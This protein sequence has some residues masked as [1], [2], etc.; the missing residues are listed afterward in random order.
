MP[1]HSDSSP[2]LPRTFLNATRIHYLD[3]LRTF[4]VLLVVVHH[5]A[6][7]KV[8]LPS[9]PIERVILNVFTA[10]NKAFLWSTFYLVSGFS[11]SLSLTTYGNGLKFLKHR[12]LPLAIHALV[13][14]TV[15][16]TAVAWVLTITTVGQGMFGS[17]ELVK[18]LLTGP[19]SYLGF[20][21]A[22]DGVLVG[23][24]AL[25]APRLSQ[26]LGRHGHFSSLLLPTSTVVTLLVCTYIN[27]SQSQRTI[28]PLPSFLSALISSFD[29]PLPD[30]PFSCI[31]AYTI[32]AHWVD[33]R[34][35]LPG[36]LTSPL[37]F[38][39]SLTASYAYLSLDTTPS[40]S[41]SYLILPF[42]PDLRTCAF[43]LWDT[44]ASLTL[45]LSLLSFFASTSVLRRSWNV[46]H[47][48]LKLLVHT[49]RFCVRLAT[50][51]EYQFR[52]SSIWLL[53]WR[54]VIDRSD[55]SGRDSSSDS[56]GDNQGPARVGKQ[57]GSSLDEF[58]HVLTSAQIHL[59]EIVVDRVGRGIL[60]YISSY[61]RIKKLALNYVVS[62][63]SGASADFATGFYGLPIGRRMVLWGA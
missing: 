13:W 53:T 16:R 58:W 18:E 29:Y 25:G 22:L 41:I 31:I 4:L 8:A 9:H 11:S 52:P 62:S 1:S 61:W 39:L 34:D 7:V 2:L 44:L 60:Q 30:A 3:N 38:P 24:R 32:G 27:A 26:L 35:S 36:S 12:S 51:P 17:Y 23:L 45:P 20:L 5:S 21:V 15:G 33:I 37:L 19:A 10:T 48:A 50:P 46:P 14:G 57:I 43:V 40:A 56:E 28:A 63:D 54:R 59:E 47:T 42:H 6:T 55:P 49:S